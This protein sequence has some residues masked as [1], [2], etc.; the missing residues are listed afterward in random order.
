MTQEGARTE[1]TDR[2]A[3]PDSESKQKDAL[4]TDRADLAWV[5]KGLNDLGERIGGIEDRMRKLEIRIAIAFGVILGAGI[6]VGVLARL[7]SFDFEIAI[8]PRQ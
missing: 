8:I 2:S 5:M 1:R 6:I 7:I 4:S 3:R